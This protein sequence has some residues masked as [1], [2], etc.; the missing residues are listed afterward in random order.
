VQRIVEAIQ[1]PNQRLAQ[2]RP[3]LLKLAPDLDDSDAIDCARAAL[4]AGC[5]GL[6]LTNTTIR[7]E[8]LR[9]ST[10]GLGGGLSGAPLFARSTQ[11][12]RRVR[13]ALGTG[14][15]LV[16]VGGV[17]D[18]EG[19]RAKLAAGADLIQVYTGLIYGGPGWVRRLLSGLGQSVPKDA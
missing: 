15:V 17:M 10:E 13:E 4:E 11:L 14:P 16:G 7:F 8:G 2:P 19:A 1:V 3:L 5:A 18:P 9:S 6:V 12:L